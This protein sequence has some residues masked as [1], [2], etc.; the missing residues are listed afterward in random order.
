MANVTGW[1]GN[2]TVAG[3]TGA[4]SMAGFGGN[5]SLTANAGADTVYGGAGSDSI[6]AGDGA[7]LVYGDADRPQTWAYRVYDRDFGASNDQAFT[8]ESGTLRGSGLATSFDVT[9][10][11]LA[12]R[13]TSGN[14]EDYGVIYT[15]TFTATVAGTYTFSTTSDDGSA[16]RMLDASGTPLVW[17]GQSTGQTGLTY[18]NND[19]H[20]GAT[21]RQASVTLAAGQSYTIEVRFWENGGADSLS[22][23]VTPPGGTSQN[24]ATSG[25]IGS[26]SATNS[27]NDSI[28]GGAGDDTLSGELGNDT[29]EGGADNDVIYGGAGQDS[30]LG[31]GGND[32]LYGGDGQ[33]TIN[34]GAGADTIHGDAGN[35]SISLGVDTL[36]GGGWVVDVGYG[37]L[38]D[39]TLSSENGS[40][41]LR[42]SLYGGDGQDSLLGGSGTDYLSGDAGHDTLEGGA[43]NDSLDGGSGDDRLFG[44]TG[45]DTLAGGISDDVLFGG[46]GAD[47]LEGGAG[48]DQLEGGDD[49]D[50]LLGG[51]GNDTLT[52]GAGAD[53]L[54]GGD[55]RDTF[56]I[57]ADGIG[58]TVDGGEGGDD[59]DTLDLRGIGKALTNIIYDPLNHENGVVQFLDAFGNVIGSMS[60]SNIENVI[61]CFTPGTRIATPQGLRLAEDL[62]PGDLVLTEDHGPQPL[63]WVGA[64]DL[65]AADLHRMPELC[66][67]RIAAGALGLGLPQRDLIVSPQH[68]MLMDG[69]RAEVLFGEAEVLVAAT[70]LVGLPG[71]TRLPA[72]AVT[73]L[74]LMCADHEILAAEGC[75]TESFQPATRMVAGMGTAQRDEIL[76]LFP[77]LAQGAGMPAAR[78]SLRA[79]EARVLLAA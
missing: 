43:G 27:G 8:I 76:T 39:D 4:D 40:D 48:H 58:D 45:N 38:G 10:H 52:G 17:S 50:T 77:E 6:L 22:A 70:H 51:A 16:M 46:A 59:Q 72:Q 37:G 32:L 34:G 21:T 73:Y 65:S 55:D 44:G 75:L 78:R 61:P 74:H 26:A 57:G 69:P 35:D 23:T 79:H 53:S 5:D 54:N 71:I 66:P 25:F 47:S 2:E 14:P 13:G 20:Q 56:I 19:F 11:T 24:L 49:A 68:R 64:R 41:T 60:F 33:D 1:T 3:T 67:V 9:N 42:D 15:A 36:G 63:I 18:L 12:A 31:D 28:L 7:D 29:I 62:R 30:L